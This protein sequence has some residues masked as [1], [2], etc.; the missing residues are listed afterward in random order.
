MSIKSGERQLNWQ[1]LNSLQPN[2]IA[3]QTLQ[4]NYTQIHDFVAS[5]ALCSAYMV[6][7]S[8]PD[9]PAL[10]ECLS[11]VFEVSD[12]WSVE[13]M[14]N[15]TDVST[16]FA[17]CEILGAVCHLSHELIYNVISA[18]QQC[19]CIFYILVSIVSETLELK[20]CHKLVQT[21]SK[22]GFLCFLW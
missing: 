4:R 15:S 22:R 8:A 11:P 18:S 5:S 16:F 12:I 13:K 14:T 7:C 17:L 6:N 19:V 2:P 3:S 9:K 10:L 21:S 20:D 1:L